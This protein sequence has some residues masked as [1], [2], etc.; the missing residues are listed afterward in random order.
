M[1]IFDKKKKVIILVEGK[2][3]YIGQINDRNDY[4]KRKYLDL[5][6]GHDKSNQVLVFW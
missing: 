4:K 3:C 5:R 1:T 2:V 6:L